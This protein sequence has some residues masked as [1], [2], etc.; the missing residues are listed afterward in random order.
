MHISVDKVSKRIRRARILD[1]I[2]LE[3]E[4][5]RIIG[6]MGPNGSGK[7]MLMRAICGLI[8][9]DRGRVVIDGK[10]LGKDISFPPSVGILIESPAFISKYT[11]F[12]NLRLL[13]GIKGIISDDDIDQALIDVGLD[14]NDRRTYRKYSLGMKQRLGIAAAL[15]ESPDLILVDEPFNALDADGIVLVHDLLLKHRERGALVIVALHDREQMDILADT[16]HVMA[17]GR[18]VGSYERSQ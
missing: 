15:M 13:A 7:T 16:I 9:P 17:Q 18:L 5:G 6:L 10:V 14:P 8:R 3:L 4:S 12:H 11:G 1:D 2:S